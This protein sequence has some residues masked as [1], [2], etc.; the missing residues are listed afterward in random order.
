MIILSQNQ[1]DKAWMDARRGCITGSRI[2]DVMA[3]LKRKDG[4]S[5]ARRNYRME[6]IVERL[7][8][9]TAEHYVSD[10][11]EHGSDCESIARAEVEID[12][13]VTVS[14]VGFVRHPTIEYSGSSPDGLLTMFGVYSCLEIKAPTSAAHLDW[15]VAG[16]VPAEHRN[17]M[18]WHMAC[19]GY[20]WCLFASY[21]PRLPEDLQLFTAAERR[22]DQRIAEIEAGVIRFE[23]EIQEYL[24]K[25]GRTGF[26]KRD[27]PKPELTAD[28]ELQAFMDEFGD[29]V[30]P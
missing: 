25:I 28:E 23:A 5:A 11:M 7:T 2:D 27:A 10:A 17:Q 29:E 9:Q 22:D 1:G 20:D 14:P 13:A 12:R 19:T 16:V 21:D 15:R 24:A 4:E 6:L 26:W 30:M 18:Q 3:V 8:G